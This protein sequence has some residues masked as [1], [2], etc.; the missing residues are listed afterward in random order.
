[1][2]EKTLKYCTISRRW[3]KDTVILPKINQ[4]TPVPLEILLPT[5]GNIIT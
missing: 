4:M 5:I 1:M 3:R 2:P